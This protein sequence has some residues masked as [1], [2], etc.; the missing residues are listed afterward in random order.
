MAKIVTPEEFINR[1]T[2]LYEG[3]YNYDKT[4]YTD[5]M[6]P[7]TITCPLHGDFVKIPNN[8]SRGYGCNECR[9]LNFPA[10]R[11]TNEQLIEK[12]NQIHNFKYD[13]SILNYNG[14][15]NKIKI[16]CKEHG[17]FEQVVDSHI[18]GRGCPKCADIN[19]V[20]NMRSTTKDFINTSI[21]KHGGKYDYSLSEYTK[22]TELIKIICPIHGLFEQIAANHL[23]G[24]GCPLCGNL[25]LRN[26]LKLEDFITRA[27][28]KHNN[29]YDYSLVKYKTTKDKVCIICPEHGTF[30]QNGDSHLR[31]CKCPKCA[32]DDQYGFKRSKFIEKYKG[33]LV[34]FYI[35]EMFGNEEKFVKIGIT[36]QTI[37]KRSPGRG[38]YNYTIINCIE[39]APDKIWDL[40]VSLKKELKTFRY[41]PLLKMDGYTECFSMK[42][43][44]NLTLIN[45]I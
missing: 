28:E 23:V 4:V 18:Q 15:K 8:H 26:V 7:I 33:K 24:C 16:I 12:L 30:W 1:V 31:G 20:I 5:S 32:E 19:R 38:V 3:F 10:L 11:Y 42:V 22:N 9:K 37:K 43:L 39:D 25:T 34:K 41:N 44:Q 21:Q 13:Y 6:T 40:E 17:V 35:L 45:L 36:G 29:F 14:V 2:L 27:S